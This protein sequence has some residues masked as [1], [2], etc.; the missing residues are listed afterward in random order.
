MVVS[1]AYRDVLIPL[2]FEETGCMT[3]FSVAMCRFSEDGPW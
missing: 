2:T 3:P 1:S